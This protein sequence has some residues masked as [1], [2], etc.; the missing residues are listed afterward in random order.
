MVF[1][2]VARETFNRVSSDICTSIQRVRYTSD[3]ERYFLLFRWKKA[4]TW[5]RRLFH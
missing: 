1:G 5:V 2:K 4:F 3:E